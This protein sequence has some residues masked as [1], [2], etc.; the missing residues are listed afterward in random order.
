MSFISVH[1]LKRRV[2]LDCLYIYR[3][4]QLHRVGERMNAD[5]FSPSVGQPPLLPDLTYIWT[6]VQSLCVDLGRCY[7]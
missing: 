4:D 3:Q 6:V 1:L 2:V 5:Y 7:C